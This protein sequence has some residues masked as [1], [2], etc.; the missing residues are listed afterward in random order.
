MTTEQPQDI[1]CNHGEQIVGR[2][3]RAIQVLE[4]IRDART[5]KNATGGTVEA[6]GPVVDTTGCVT[7]GTHKPDSGIQI[8]IDPHHVIGATIHELRRQGRLR[9]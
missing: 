2:L 6:P 9:E 7:Q 8:H 1:C 3:D 5:A 4:E